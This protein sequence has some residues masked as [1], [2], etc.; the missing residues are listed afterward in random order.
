LPSAAPKLLNS[1]VSKRKA[2]LK[3]YTD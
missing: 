2:Y 3:N 1:P